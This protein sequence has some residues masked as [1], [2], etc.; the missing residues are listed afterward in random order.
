M[1]YQHLCELADREIRLGIADERLMHRALQQ[2][3][4][5]VAQAHQTYWRLRASQLQEQARHQSRAGTLTRCER[6][7]ARRPSLDASL[8]QSE[9]P[10]RQS[11]RFPSVRFSVL[12]VRPAPK[13]DA[14]NVAAFATSPSVL[15][16]RAC[17]RPAMPVCHC[18]H[19]VVCD[20]FRR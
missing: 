13:S 19:V 7:S 12:P 9:D 16:R 18:S 15:S 8:S 20:H 1:D 2:S 14:R 5:V 3:A 10:K 11:S 6:L 17:V 4:G